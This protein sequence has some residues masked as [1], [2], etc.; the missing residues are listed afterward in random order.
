MVYGREKME[1][2]EEFK[3]FWSLYPKQTGKGAA[4]S[5]WKKYKKSEHELILDHLPQRIKT[6]ADW[7]EG[8]FIKNPATWLNQRCWEDNYKRASQFA[9]I[10]G[11]KKETW[12]EKCESYNFTQRHEDICDNG[13]EFYHVRFKNKKWVFK[14]SGAEQLE[15]IS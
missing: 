10:A 1:Y 15:T 3:E 6:D 13:E 4:F 5:S 11:I 2:T 14:M 8:K 7:L 12:C 9:R